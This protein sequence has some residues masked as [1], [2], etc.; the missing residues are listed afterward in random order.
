MKILE[1]NCG[2]IRV[3]ISATRLA[4]GH[5]SEATAIRSREP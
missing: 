1:G 3:P 4:A 5:S 2:S